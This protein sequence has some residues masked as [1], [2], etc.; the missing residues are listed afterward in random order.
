MELV[1]FQKKFQAAFKFRLQTGKAAT[2]ESKPSSIKYTQK[3]LSP[4][5]INAKLV[6]T[7]TDLNAARKEKV[8]GSGQGFLGRYKDNV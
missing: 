3:H 7:T 4:Y 5:L 1:A 2:A 6:E 8:L